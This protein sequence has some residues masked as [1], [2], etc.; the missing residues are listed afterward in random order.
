MECCIGVSIE[1]G[2]NADE[3]LQSEMSVFFNILSPFTTV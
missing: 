3:G 1:T 2:V